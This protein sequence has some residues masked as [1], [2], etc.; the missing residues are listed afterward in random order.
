[1]KLPFPILIYYSL[2][3]VKSISLTIL[4]CFFGFLLNVKTFRN[5]CEEKY[6]YSIIHFIL[7]NIFRTIY[8][9]KFL[10]LPLNIFSL[11]FWVFFFASFFCAIFIYFDSISS[12]LAQFYDYFQDIIATS[13]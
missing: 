2:P 8:I 4:I 7:M 12:I 10:V 13:M 3:F 5:T 1:M 11:F 9:R 6:L